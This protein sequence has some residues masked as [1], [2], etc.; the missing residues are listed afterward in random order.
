MPL[1]MH[2]ISVTNFETESSYMYSNKYQIFHN[3]C[4]SKFKKLVAARVMFYLWKGGHLE[5][6]N[7]S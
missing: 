4:C 6:T 5:S 2:I 1:I 3:I 7:D